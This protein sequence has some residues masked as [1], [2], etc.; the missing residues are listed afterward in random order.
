[1]AILLG[2]SDKQIDSINRDDL[3]QARLENLTARTKLVQQ[4]IAE[5]KE[6][7]WNE[8]NACCF[9]EFSAAFARVKNTLISMHL[10]DEQIKTLN[11]GLDKALENFRDRLNVMYIKFIK[12]EEKE[13]EE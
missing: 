3:I 9:E 13:L 11:E 4:K 10:N 6:A 12:G 7:A 5:E 2:I 8:W 1:M